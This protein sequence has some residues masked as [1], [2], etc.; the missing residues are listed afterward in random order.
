MVEWH[1]ELFTHRNLEKSYE[2]SEL[3]VIVDARSIKVAFNDG[4]KDAIFVL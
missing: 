2:D 1:H 3:E 4:A